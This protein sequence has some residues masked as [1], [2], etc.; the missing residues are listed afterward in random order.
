MDTLVNGKLCTYGHL[1]KT[2][3]FST[4]I[5]TLYFYIP[6]SGQL[7]L[8]T[9]FT[10][11]EGARLWELSL[12]YIFTRLQKSILYKLVNFWELNQGRKL[13]NL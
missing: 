4:S 8:Q 5:Q 3:F 11:P 6:V 7:W 13:Q 10:R 1:H 12:Y 2:L 9:P